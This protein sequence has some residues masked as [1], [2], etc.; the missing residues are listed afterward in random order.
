MEELLTKIVG[1]IESAEIPDSDKE[2]L[3][4]FIRHALQASVVPVLV[5]R[6]PK[7]RLRAYTHNLSTLTPDA[8]VRFVA[9]AI[10]EEG[11]LEEIA[12]SMGSILG[13]IDAALTEAGV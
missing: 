4:V 9:D 8:Y 3:Y 6:L 7:D 2:H 12:E 11:A 10:R 13:E 5:R 1:R